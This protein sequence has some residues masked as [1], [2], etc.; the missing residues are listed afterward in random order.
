MGCMCRLV[1]ARRGYWMLSLEGGIHRGFC[2]G[3]TRRDVLRIGGMALGGLSLPGLLRA[4]AAAAGQDGTGAR[5]S[6]KAVIMVFLAG[7]PPQHD[8][9]DLKPDAPSEIRGEFRPI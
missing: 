7:G 8:T 3:V 9:F 2:D 6:H 4:E 1:P 5:P